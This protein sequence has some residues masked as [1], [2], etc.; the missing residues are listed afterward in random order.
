MSFRLTPRRLRLLS[1]YLTFVLALVGVVLFLGGVVVEIFS[2]RNLPPLPGWDLS[3]VITLALGGLCLAA[4]MSVIWFTIVGWQLA[5]QS[6]AQGAYYA[7]AYRLIEAFRF[8]EAIPLLERSLQ[9]GKIT[10]ELLLL[11]TSAY[12]Y[13]GQLAKAQATADRAVQLFPNDPQAYITLANGY[14]LQAA[15]DAAARVLMKAA[16][17]APDQPVIWAELGFAQRFA[18]ETEAAVESF[19]MAAQFD[20]PQMYAVRVYFHLMNAYRAAGDAAQAGKAAM[21]MV[22]AARG[23]VVWQTGLAALEGTAYGQA[24]RY[25]VQSVAAAVAEAEAAQNVTRSRRTAAED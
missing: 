8:R 9:E 13:S 19:K 3:P 2:R 7:D 15:Y 10:S 12:G 14:R 22:G 17:L 4:L 16:A 1:L 25:E 11:L 5:K 20:L 6:R 18:G 21:R 24:L 23:I